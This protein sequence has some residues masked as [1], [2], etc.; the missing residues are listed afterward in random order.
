MRQWRF[1]CCR[2][3]WHRRLWG[4]ARLRLLVFVWAGVWYGVMFWLLI[5]YKYLNG[6]HTLALQ[7]LGF[8]L[9]GIALQLWSWPMRWWMDLWQRRP[10]LP[11]RLGAW[12]RWRG[13]PAAFSTGV[14][15]FVVAMSISQ[16]SDP[17][18]EP[19][20]ALSQAATWVRENVRD[21]VMICDRQLLVGYYALHPYTRWYGE[22]GDPRMDEIRNIKAHWHAQTGREPLIMLG[23]L[24][25]KG[26]GITETMG[27]YRAVAMFGGADSPAES[28]RA[29][30]DVYVFYALPGERVFKDGRQIVYLTSWHGNTGEASR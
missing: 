26:K 17:P 4:R 25:E 16:L 11:I 14:L 9:L 5:T 20:R 23:H 19:S 30:K 12:S 3:L 29:G 22:P 2:Q 24:Y 7:V 28:D 1:C 21:D 10:A 13:W 18:W 8:A 15:G 27:D 6:R